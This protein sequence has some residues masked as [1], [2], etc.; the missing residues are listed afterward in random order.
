MRHFRNFSQREVSFSS[1]K[2]IIIG[3][4]GKG[5]TNILEALA[6]PSW[7]LVETQGEYLVERGEKIFHVRYILEHW[8]YSCSY[9]KD[10][11]KKQYFSGKNPCSRPKLIAAYPHIVSFHPLVMNMMYLSPSE[12]RNFLDQILSQSFP[13]YKKYLSEYKKILISRN[14]VLKN[15]FEKKSESSELDFWNN[16]FIKIASYIYQK[17]KQLVDFLSENIWELQKYFFGKIDTIDFVY[18]SKIDIQDISISLWE[19]ISENR[20][21]EI[22]ARRTCIW[23]HLDD[24]DI[25]VDDIPLI[26]FASRWEVKSSILALKFLETRFI[27]I[28]SE[29]TDIVFLIDDLLSELDTQHRNMLWKHVWDRQCI[30]SSIEDSDIE[31]NKIFI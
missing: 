29:K 20:E 16:A 8:E 15:I 27:E 23:P 17:R 10:T 2:N 4:N 26:H 28:H 5:K 7:S 25:L 14:R 30:V 19:S 9:E 3:N 1:G 31:G 11:K 13:E 24:F 21:K 12:R 22:L 18:S 6:L